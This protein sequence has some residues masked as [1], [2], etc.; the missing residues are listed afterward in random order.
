MA[1]SGNPRFGYDR[2][3]LDPPLFSANS[4]H[5]AAGQFRSISAWTLVRSRDGRTGY[6][7][8]LTLYLHVCPIGHG[9]SPAEL[10][11]SRIQRHR[12]DGPFH[13]ANRYRWVIGTSLVHPA[14]IA[15]RLGSN[16][17]F[18]ANLRAAWRRRECFPTSTARAGTV[19]RY[20][21]RPGPSLP[22]PN[23]R[24]KPTFRRTHRE[25]IAKTPD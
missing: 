9:P 13:Y 3:P 16:P 10:S 4:D 23:T 17:R 8:G 5:F 11:G 2:G 14:G 20:E 7:G 15:R 12:I 19:S 6:A 18:E 21:P 22:F 24:K 25:S 1:E